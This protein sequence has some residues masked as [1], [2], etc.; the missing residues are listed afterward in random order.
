MGSLLWLRVGDGF[1]GRDRVRGILM[2]GVGLQLRV[3]HLRDYGIMV[4]LGLQLLVQLL[5]QITVYYRFGRSHGDSYSYNYS[6]GYGESKIL[7]GNQ[8]MLN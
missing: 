8:C 3:V 7:E 1:R 2:A 4:W 5:V 6:Y